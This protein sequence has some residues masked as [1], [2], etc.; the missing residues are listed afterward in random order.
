MAIA[1]QMNARS[2]HNKQDQIDRTGMSFVLTLLAYLVAAGTLAGALIA[3]AAWLVHVPDPLPHTART[4]APLP[5]KIAD[6]IARKTEAPPAPEKK[7][8]VRS[9]PVTAPHV[10][11]RDL[12]PPPSHADRRQAGGHRT[13]SARKNPRRQDFAISASQAQ[14]PAEPA[15]YSQQQMSGYAPRGDRHGN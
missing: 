7:E 1:A 2:G 5:P 6:S 8:A 12:S 4:A 13:R 10:V 14:K 15:P 9:E 3:G 11:L